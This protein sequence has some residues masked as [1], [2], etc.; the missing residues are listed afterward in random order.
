MQSSKLVLHP[1]RERR[2][3]GGTGQLSPSPG[4]GEAQEAGI[5]GDMGTAYLS[6]PRIR[7]VFKP[8]NLPSCRVRKKHIGGM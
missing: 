1:V 4:F 6:P 8:V 2:D 7:A 5:G 3:W